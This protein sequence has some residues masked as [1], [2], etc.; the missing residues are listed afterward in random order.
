MEY[1]GVSHFP[2]SVNEKL[3][4]ETTMEEIKLSM[5][6][7]IIMPEREEAVIID[8]QKKTAR[9]VYGQNT[10]EP[11]K[12][13]LVLYYQNN[14]WKINGNEPLPFYDAD[15]LTD[16]TALGKFLLK[17]GELKVGMIVE[18]RKGDKGFY[19]IDLEVRSYA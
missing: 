16:N 14:R 12:T 8:I 15:K 5:K 3:K 4:G 19:K 17:Y 1:Y 18:I 10:K 6:D 13:I 2:I 11:D 7:V 9:D